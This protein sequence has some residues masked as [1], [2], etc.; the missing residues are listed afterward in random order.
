MPI[1]EYQCEKCNRVTEMLQGINDPPIKKCSYCKGKVKRVIS[2]SAFHLK[3]TGWY[4]TDYAK[5]AGIPPEV[6]KDNPA[7]SDSNGSS[8]GNKTEIKPE[9]LKKPR[10]SDMANMEKSDVK[11][12]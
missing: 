10:K 12:E 1:Y 9:R 2:L 6:A 7:L 4:A 8:N 3:G 11:V 5:N